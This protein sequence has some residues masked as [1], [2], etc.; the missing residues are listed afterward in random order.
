MLESVPLAQPSLDSLIQRM[1]TEL[2][3]KAVLLL[4][5]NGQVLYRS[6][7]IEESHYPAMAA[8]I[9]AMISAGRSLS[10]LGEAFSG[11]P[12]RFGCDSEEMGLYTVAVNEQYWLAALYD[13]PTNPGLIRMKVRRF[14]DTFARL[15][16][17][18]PL[19]WE[20]QESDSV[21]GASLPPAGMKSALTFEKVTQEDSSL[22]A[23]ITDEEIDRLFE[24]AGN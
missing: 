19:Q 12:S 14:A 11:S 15:G 18:K 8:L 23:N 9:A 4:H 2:S 10:S 5:E 3:A 13:Q 7:S 6:G 17:T 24:D 16:L 21:A 22:F 1:N 20:V